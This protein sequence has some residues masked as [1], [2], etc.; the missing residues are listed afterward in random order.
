V[1]FNDKNY[2]HCNLGWNGWC[3]GWYV[4]G[5][6]DTSPYIGEYGITQTNIPWTDTGYVEYTEYFFDTD[7]RMLTK[8]KKK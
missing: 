6:F 8:K 5:V 1:D 7:I 2:V 3:N 4:D